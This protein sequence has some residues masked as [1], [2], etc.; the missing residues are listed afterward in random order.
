MTRF[1]QTAWS[2]FFDPLFRRPKRLQV[3]ALCY[4]KRRSG[5][6]VLLITSL[7]T[8]RW[9][10]PKG[11]PIDGLDEAGSALQEAW[12]EAGVRNGRIANA[13][14]GSFEYRKRF[15]GGAEATCLTQVFPVEVEDLADEFPESEERKRKWVRPEQAASMVEEPELQDLLRSF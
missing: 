3:A 14:I 4:R 8:G 1:M 13:P 15:Q 10:L 12:E 2:E 9:I 7:D 11:W 6:E 5:K